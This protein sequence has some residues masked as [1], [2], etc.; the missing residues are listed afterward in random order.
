MRGLHQA[1]LGVVQV[2]AQ[3][4]VARTQ[5]HDPIKLQGR[6]GNICLCAQK[7]EICFGEYIS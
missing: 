5:S 1:G 6:L 4:R 3:V 7:K 2:T